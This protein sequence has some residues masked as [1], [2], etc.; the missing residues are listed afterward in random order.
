[1]NESV[2]AEV[3][4]AVQGHHP[5]GSLRPGDRLGEGPRPSSSASSTSC[6]W[7]TRT[8]PAIFRSLEAKTPGSGGLFSIFVSDL[9]KGCG[10]CVQVCGDH[11]ALRMTTRDGGAERRADD[12][13]D[14]LAPAARHAAEIPR[15]LQRRRRRELARGRAAQPPD[16]PAQL[17]GAGVRRRRVRRLRREE[18][19]ARAAPAS[20]RPT[21]AR[22]ITRRPTASAAKAD[23]P[24][25][26]G[27][28][29]TG[30]R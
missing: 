8:C 20:P 21:C 9:C 11:D 1:M 6:R 22:S 30:R 17:R 15:P 24:G 10:E 23:A 2:K 26:G 13:A 5:R 14:L 27:A 28:G 25:K 29:E 12:R 16:G 18:R 3:Q 4:R 19:P 7:P